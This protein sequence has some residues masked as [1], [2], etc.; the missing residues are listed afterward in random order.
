MFKKIL[1]VLVAAIALFAIYVAVQPDDFAIERS[2]VVEAPAPTVFAQVNDF[3]NWE[4]W[5]PWAKLDP[6]SVATFEGATSGQGA[7]FRWAGN[8]QVGE[9]KMTIVE[10]DPYD[11][12]K[13]KL[14]FFKPFAGT[15]DTLFTFKPQG[16]GTQVDWKMSGKNNFIGKAMCVV[17]N[18]QDM[19][20]RQFDQGLASIKKI[21]EGKS[22]APQ[23]ATA[24]PAEGKPA[25]AAK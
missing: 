2:T 10:S 5:S 24:E 7:I 9:G 17:M 4:A 11:H 6:N 8:D 13:I 16:T 3:H 19:V 23:P 20:G 21:A 1:I 25:E 14:E 15:N 12:I 22:A 18:M